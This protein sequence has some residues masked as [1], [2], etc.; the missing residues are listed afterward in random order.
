VLAITQMGVHLMFFLHI[1][2][3]PDNTNNVGAATTPSARAQP[4]VVPP[5]GATQNRAT[6][7]QV[8]KPGDDVRVRC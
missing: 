4:H 8:F 6:P 2:P 3:G 1:T 7:G 5:N